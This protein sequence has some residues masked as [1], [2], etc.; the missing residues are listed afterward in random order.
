MVKIE[1][2]RTE[3]P[4]TED[5]KATYAD[6]I[7]ILVNQPI[8]EGLTVAQIRRDF[9]I[10]DA[11]SDSGVESFELEEAQLKHVAALSED[12]QWPVRHMD[13]VAFSDYLN[14]L[15]NELK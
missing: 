5:T 7:K 10:L 4:F 9:L 11:V 6:L 1:N 12:A 15:V 14:E 8:R 3:I 13:V 2:K